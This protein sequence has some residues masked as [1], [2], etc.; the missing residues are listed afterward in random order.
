MIREAEETAMGAAAV[1]AN[2]TVVGILGAAWG[3]VPD[4]CDIIGTESLLAAVAGAGGP[5][6]KALDGSGATKAAQ[7]A[8][9]RERVEHDHDCGAVC[10]SGWRSGDDRDAS[11]DSAEALGDEDGH[12]GR[13]LSGAAARAFTA[14]AESAR[15]E[16]RAA[17]TAEDLLRA[18]LSDD[19]NRAVETL[20]TCG[21]TPERVRARLD[22]GEPGPDGG[23]LDAA[24]W[25]TRDALLGRPLPRT[26]FWRRL[27]V[28]LAQEGNL[29]TLPVLWATWDSREQARA[30]GQTEGTEHIVLA[31]LATYEVV[32]AHPHMARE[33]GAD[34][35]R[36]FAGGARLAQQGIDY[37][38]VR[39]ALADGPDL[40]REERDADH[41]LDAAEADDDHGTG[42]LLE[43][44]L[45]DDTR[46]RRLL[47]S[48]SDDDDND[49]EDGDEK[50]ESGNE[51]GS[52]G[53]S[54]SG[55]RRGSRESS[56]A[57]STDSGGWTEATSSVVDL[58]L[59]GGAHVGRFVKSL[60]NAL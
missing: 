27:M 56:D 47:E 18:L 17:Y 20:R 42:R 1:E 40:G 51:G 45:R 52:G 26:R 38:T 53:G 46:G 8:V 12:P 5:A 49:I 21:I 33:G 6:G 30:L 55:D 31:L 43:A 25:P 59:V 54:G 36:R 58:I 22:G 50:L 13:R 3:A 28:G 41:Y 24:L 4:A 34:P 29:A 7:L 16:K 48:L 23:G 2:G 57:E 35:E 10:E 14:A 37:A 15:R 60:G 32:L 9:I 39:R 19:G 44:L 11:V